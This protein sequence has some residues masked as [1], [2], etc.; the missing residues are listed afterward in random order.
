[1][2]KLHIA[3]IG[4]VCIS[5]SVIFAGTA[6]AIT[7]PNPTTLTFS[8]SELETLFG[9]DVP[10]MIGPH[11]VIMS[12]EEAE[13]VEGKVV[14]VVVVGVSTVVGAGVAAVRGDN[15]LVGAAQG[16]LVGVATVAG[17]GLA[18]TLVGGSAATTI[19]STVSGGWFTVATEAACYACHKP[20]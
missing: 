12:R 7:K 17:G 4:A 14:P 18:G 5:C 9:G 1:M 6:I 11:P 15:I 16:A 8:A 3:N 19:G 20:N 2:K 13:Q 10:K